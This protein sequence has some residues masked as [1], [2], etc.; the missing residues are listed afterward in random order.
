MRLQDAPKPVEPPLGLAQ[1]AGARARVAG[2]GTGRRSS[3]RRKAA[4]GWGLRQAPQRGA[5]A[6]GDEGGFGELL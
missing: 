4:E 1:T 6:P 5:E 2:R 3:G